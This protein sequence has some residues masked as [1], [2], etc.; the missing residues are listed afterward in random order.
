MDSSGSTAAM[1]VAA[2]AL[3]GLV[4]GMI[5][6]G[7]P[8]VAMALLTLAMPPAA[9]ASLLVVPSLVTNVW[10]LAHGPAFGALA[11]RLWPLLA[12]IV[13]G[14]FAGGL[15]PLAHAAPW[16][17][18]A[19][20]AVVALYGAWGLA[21]PRLPAPGHRERWLAPL[22]GYLTGAIT[23]AT[24]VFVMPAVPYLQA[25]RLDKA[26]LV[27]ALGLS[28]TVSTLALAVQLAF[29]SGWQPVDLGMSALALVPALAGMA[30]GTILRNRV[31]EATFR[32]AWFAGF[33]ALGLYMAVGPARG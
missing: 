6:L 15:P 32:H 28:F 17:R 21:A 12:G 18:V 24:G 25:L 8:T 11:R 30:G 27:Q 3:A 23:A 7:L 33:V 4:K 1:V 13:A 22:A 26:Q 16:T 20:G 14:T 2:F 5:G 29:T 10:Q 9:A 19:L 31:G